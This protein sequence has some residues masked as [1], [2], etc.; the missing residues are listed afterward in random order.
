[1]N[2]SQSIEN[3]CGIFHHFMRKRAPLDKGGGKHSPPSPG[4]SSRRIGMAFPGNAPCRCREAGQAPASLASTTGSGDWPSIHQGSPA[5]FQLPDTRQTEATSLLISSSSNAQSI[6]ASCR[7]STGQP[8]A[9]ALMISC[10]RKRGLGSIGRTQAG[11]N[12]QFS[13]LGPW[14]DKE[15]VVACRKSAFHR[16]KIA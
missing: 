14:D 13:Q 12:S 4:N 5:S 3:L 7:S 11:R 9:S 2:A 10:F 1:M 6:R 8:S 15:V 16:E